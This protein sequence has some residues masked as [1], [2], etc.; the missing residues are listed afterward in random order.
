MEQLR[1]IWNEFTS[2]ESF[3]E[4]AKKDAAGEKLELLKGM[5]IFFH[6]FDEIEDCIKYQKNP[7][8]IIQVLDIVSG[9]IMQLQCF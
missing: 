1:Q 6:S 2:L 8:E 9:I 7:E 5:Q 3:V 4:E